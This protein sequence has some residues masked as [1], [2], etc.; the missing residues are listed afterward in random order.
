MVNLFGGLMGFKSQGSFTSITQC[1][2]MF[3]DVYVVRL[4]LGV[5]MTMAFDLSL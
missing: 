3:I 1:S 4:G 5:I 2:L